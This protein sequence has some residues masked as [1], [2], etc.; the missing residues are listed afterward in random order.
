MTEKRK[1]FCREYLKSGNITTAAKK[2]GYSPR[3]AYSQ[4]SRL[5]KKDEIKEYLKKLA[6]K[7]LEKEKEG[8]EYEL[9]HQLKAIALADVTDDIKVETYEYLIPIFDKK[10]KDTGKKE[11]KISQRVTIK[12]SD[13]FRHNRA[14]A[15]I[16]QKKDGIKITYASKEKAIEMLGRIQGMFNDKI[17]H[18]VHVDPEGTH[19][20]VSGF[21]PYKGTEVPEK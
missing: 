19:N 5:Y 2:A 15:S 4:G 3:S 21:I 12:D 16:E 13:Q 11:T 8:L 6:T 7:L 14:V 20:A 18:T 17:D 9:I 1:K 10:G